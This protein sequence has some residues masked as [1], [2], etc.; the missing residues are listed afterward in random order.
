MYE[1][2]LDIYNNN[3]RIHIPK[4]NQATYR[5]CIL[6]LTIKT[7]IGVYTYIYIYIY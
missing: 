7:T 1:F 4:L 2:M 3:T 5:I 6:L